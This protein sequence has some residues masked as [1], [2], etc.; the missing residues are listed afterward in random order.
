VENAEVKLDI[1]PLPKKEGRSK[2]A[3]EEAAA[4]D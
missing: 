4:T 1:K 2:P 3:A